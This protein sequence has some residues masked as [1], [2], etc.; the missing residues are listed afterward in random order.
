MGKMKVI[1]GVIEAVRYD[2]EGNVVMARAYERRGKIYSDVVLLSRLDLIMK[3]TNQMHFA[4]GSR[5]D[6]KG[7][8]F[9]LKKDIRLGGQAGHEILLSVGID[10]NHDDLT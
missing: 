8:V 3:L 10:S 5:K 9:D 6:G 2:P 1:D 7:G 4:I